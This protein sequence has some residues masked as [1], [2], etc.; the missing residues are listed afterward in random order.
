MTLEEGYRT[1]FCDSSCHISQENRP[2]EVTALWRRA[3]NWKGKKTSITLFVHKPES[4][5]ARGEK[6]LRPTFLTVGIQW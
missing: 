3:R 6:L 4:L 2:C 1:W 5:V